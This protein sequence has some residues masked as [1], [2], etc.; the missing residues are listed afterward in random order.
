ML[1]ALLRMPIAAKCA[2]IAALI[3]SATGLVLVIASVKASGLLLQQSA[4]LF[5]RQWIAQLALQAQQPMLRQDRVSLQSILR[6]HT[7]NPLVAHGAILDADHQP[8]VEAGE[9]GRP[10]PAFSADITLGPEIAGLAQISLD[11]ESLRNEVRM[12]GWQLF[13]LTAVLTGLASALVAVPAARLDEWLRG[14]RTRLLQPLAETEAPP[15]PAADSLGELLHGV[16][17]PPTP[18]YDS[19]EQQ[20]DWVLLHIRWQA[21]GRLSQQWGQAQLDQRLATSYRQAA[22]VA[23]LYHGELKLYRGDGLS[24]RFA[25]L[26]GA[27]D[28]LFRALCSA[29]LLQALGEELGAVSYLGLLR[30]QGNTWQLQAAEAQ[31]AQTLHAAGNDGRTQLQLPAEQRERLQHWAEVEGSQVTEILPPYDALL[32]RQ[33]A[34]LR[35]AF[36]EN[37][38]D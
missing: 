27:D 5:G 20:A 21:F 28:A 12:L 15:Y 34:R 31:L 18:S 36:A 6:S 25:E 16:H 13:L 22:A 17:R 38:E 24:L 19:A 26:P 4:D 23:Q 8:I 10:G 1:N 37:G 7:D 11:G 2:L 9:R 29:Q 32:A 14:A 3:S 35:A 33:L 30:R